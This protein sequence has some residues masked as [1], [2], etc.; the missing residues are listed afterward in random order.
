MTP[1]ADRVAVCA[2]ACV[3][4]DRL[5]ERAEAAEGVKVTVTVQLEPAVSVEPQVVE[6]RLKSEP[7]TTG[8]ATVMVSM[9]VLSSVAVAVDDEPT[10]VEV[11]L[12]VLS[13]ALGA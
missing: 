7:L 13:E 4:T 8:A 6:A 2:P 10:K 12:G 11:K 3:P 9:P 1:V 5:P